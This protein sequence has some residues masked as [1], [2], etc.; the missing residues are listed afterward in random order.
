MKLD[1]ESLA[2]TA[3]IT[4]AAVFTICT[5]LLALFPEFI[6]RI[7]SNV[8]HVGFQ[9][10]SGNLTLTSYVL[11]LCFWAVGAFVVFAIAG[12]IYNRLSA[13]GPA[14]ISFPSG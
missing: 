12:W 10:S 8:W 3:A 9:S 6:A 5:A 13:R 4:S 11:G 14:R 7:W 2:A 1:T